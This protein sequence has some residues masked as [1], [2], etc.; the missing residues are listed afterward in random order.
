MPETPKDGQPAPEAAPATAP[1][2][3]V[4]SATPSAGA[5]AAPANPLP[6]A[7]ATP[8]SSAAPAAPKPAPPAPKPA[9]VAWECEMVEQLKLGY[10]AGILNAASYLGQ[11]YLVV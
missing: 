1:G 2:Q 6:S 8:A 10:G 11:N 5:P 9:P 7:A 4:P 3:T